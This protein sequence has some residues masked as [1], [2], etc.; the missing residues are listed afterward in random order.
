QMH[1]EVDSE[2][3]AMY[4]LTEQQITSQIQLQFTGQTAAQY[5]EDG[6][7]MD[8]TLMFPEDERS[9]IND[10]EDMKIQS[11]SGASVPLASLVTLEEVQG[12][13]TLQR[14]NQQPQLNVTSEIIG[15]DLGSITS[16]ISQKLDNMSFPE[17]YSYDMGGQAQDMA[18]SFTDLS[19]AL[20][21]SIFLVYAV[22][23]VQFENFLF[24]FIIMFSLPATVVGVLVGLFVTGLPLSIPAF[25]GI[26]MLAG[27]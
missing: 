22:M 5:R 25:I 27:I 14:E 24:P 19:I 12:P 23:A 4:G 13:V 8:I 10:V 3:A 11:E 6:N 21:F 20:V 17:G 16:D 15:R 26:I 9:T 7:E 1:I 18:E 2:K